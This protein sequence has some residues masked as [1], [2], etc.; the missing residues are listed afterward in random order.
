MRCRAIPSRC[1]VG[2][3][4]TPEQ[5]AEA[6][7]RLGL[8]RRSLVQ[9]AT[10]LKQRRSPAI[11]APR[12]TAASRCCISSPSGCRRPCSSPSAATLVAPAA[13]RPGRRGRARLR[14]AP[15]STASSSGWS[16]LA[17][18][19]PDLLAR[20][21]AH[22]ALRGELHWLPS[23]SGYVPFWESPVADAAQRAAAGPDPRA[24]RLRHLRPLPARL[25]RR[26]AQVP[27]MSAPRAPKACASAT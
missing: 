4:A 12:S 24:L 3:N 18:G 10:W 8:D 11:S 13:R 9:Y 25:A 26:R 21:P 2:E 20:H 22:P 5:I 7:R 27:T 6:T 23:A 19:V 16:A 1:I 14:P 17:L 15:G